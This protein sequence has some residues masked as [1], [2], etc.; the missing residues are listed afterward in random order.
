MTSVLIRR[1][2]HRGDGQVK[3]QAEIAA[4]WLQVKDSQQPPEAKTEAWDGVS[5]RAPE[6]TNPGDTLILD[7]WPPDLW[8]NKS[9]V[10]SH[11]VCGHLLWRPQE[12][13]IAV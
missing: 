5:L 13:N 1:G 7:F 2:E 3:T 10:L 12:T 8:E 9:V 4:M 6:G 11:P